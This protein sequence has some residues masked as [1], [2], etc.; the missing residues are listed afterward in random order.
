MQKKNTKI[1][2]ILNV[3]LVLLEIFSVGWMM[4][5]IRIEGTSKT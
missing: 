3:V 4:S 5:G 1:A 2:F